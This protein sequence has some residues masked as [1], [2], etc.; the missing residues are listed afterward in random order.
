M[1]VVISEIVIRGEVEPAGGRAQQEARPAEGAPLTAR[2]RR[3]LVE[4]A[5][6]EVLRVLERKGER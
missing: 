1:A 4:E 3:L 2:D 6:E 5:V